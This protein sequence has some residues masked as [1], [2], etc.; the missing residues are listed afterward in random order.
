MSVYTNCVL[1]TILLYLLFFNIGVQLRKVTM[2]TI[3][4]LILKSI[5]I[6]T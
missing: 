2:V 4:S 1:S 3:L 6:F 5:Y